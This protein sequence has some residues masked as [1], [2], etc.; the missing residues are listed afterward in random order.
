[1]TSPDL[2]MARHQPSPD[3]QE[4]D[5]LDQDE[6]VDMTEIAAENRDSNDSSSE[7]SKPASTANANGKPNPKD[8]LRPRRKKARR[9]CFACQRAHLT[10]GKLTFLSSKTFDTDLS[11]R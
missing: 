4:F 3:D 1:M 9:A 8:P 10:C 2:E 5:D 11:L 7:P 6:T